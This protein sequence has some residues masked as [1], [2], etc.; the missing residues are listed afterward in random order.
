[1]DGTPVPDAT[2]DL[3]HERSLVPRTPFLRNTRSRMSELSAEPAYASW[4]QRVGAKAIDAV[5]VASPFLALG[6]VLT[7]VYQDDNPKTD[8]AS[9]IGALMFI[10][11]LLLSPFYFALMHGRPSGQTVGKQNNRIAV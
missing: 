6:V 3:V 8:D 9:A 11:I 4:G 7:L 1:M 2:D 5:I 10:P